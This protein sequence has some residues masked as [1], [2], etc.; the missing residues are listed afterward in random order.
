MFT[1]LIALMLLRASST[2]IAI[3]A[4]DLK[5]SWTSSGVIG[6]G[7]GVL[8]TADVG[9]NG[10]KWDS[11]TRREWFLLTTGNYPGGVSL[12]FNQ[13]R[14]LTIFNL[15]M[16]TASPFMLEFTASGVPDWAD[17]VVTITH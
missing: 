14:Q 17:V 16:A 7:S 1:G 8:F 15:T 5:I 9:P 10:H 2:P 4:G 13:T 3:P 6:A 11:P 12:L